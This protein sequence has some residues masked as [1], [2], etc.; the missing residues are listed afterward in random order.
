MKCTY[1]LP[2][3][4]WLQNTSAITES[5]RAEF[6]LKDLLVFFF[7]KAYFLHINIY[8][9]CQVE[10]PFIRKQPLISLG[11]ELVPINCIYHLLW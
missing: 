10:A 5:S 3:R 2:T 11:S 1:P 6:F 7:K 8:A 4:L 9:C